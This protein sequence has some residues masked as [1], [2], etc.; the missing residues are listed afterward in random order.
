MIIH[1][2]IDKDYD[3]KYLCDES[4]RV[5]IGEFSQ[6]WKNVTCVKCLKI[7]VLEK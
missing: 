6:L 4:I 2:L 1:K 7:K 3:Y 5:T